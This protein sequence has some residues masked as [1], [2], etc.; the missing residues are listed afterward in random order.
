M[1]RTPQFKF[2]D[3]SQDLSR[4]FELYDMRNDPKEERNLAREPRHRDAVEDFKRQLT[5][6]RAA[7]PA[8]VR[9]PGMSVPD[10]AA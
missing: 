1:V 8:P 5:A 2:I 9:I 3:L 10:Y 4:D 6:W 7:K